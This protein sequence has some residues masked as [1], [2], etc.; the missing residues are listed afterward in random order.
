MNCVA[1]MVVNDMLLSILMLVQAVGLRALSSVQGMMHGDGMMV[2]VVFV[3][4]AV[5]NS[6]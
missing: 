5:V 1:W 6:M 2:A 4:V 3:V